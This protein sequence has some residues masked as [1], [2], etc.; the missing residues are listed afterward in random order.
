MGNWISN[1]LFWALWFPAMALTMGYLSRVRLRKPAGLRTGELKHPW[2]TL[3]LGLA[4]LLLFGGFGL[5][6]LLVGPQE[7]GGERQYRG[8]MA[9]FTLFAVLFLPVI[10]EYRRSRHRVTDEGIYYQPFLR[11]GGFL[12][13]SDVT[14]VRYSQV[15]KWFRLDGA[16]GEVAR[17]SVMLLGLPEFASQLLDHVP[18]SAIE[19][20]SLPVLVA[21][22][23]GHPPSIW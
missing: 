2:T 1:V 21:T 4:G 8:L 9:A 11:R 19:E 23:E 16:S 3:A 20:A 10:I 6:V 17:I 13:W 7:F 18:P 12:K 5:M 15:N 14:R 22:R